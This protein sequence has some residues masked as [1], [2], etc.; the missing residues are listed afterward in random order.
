VKIGIVLEGASDKAFFEKLLFKYFQEKNTQFLFRV[1]QG[2]NNLIRQSP[3]W[4]NFFR[5]N[6]CDG[7]IVIADRDKEPCVTAVLDLFDSSIK[8][9]LK[10]PKSE[11]FF[12]VC[13]AVRGLESWLL[14]DEAAIN[15]LS[16]GCGY[17]PPNDTGGIDPK[18]T[19]KELGFTFDK[20][21]LSKSIAPKFHPDRAI[22]HSPS[23]AYFWDCLQMKLTYIE[24]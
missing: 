18:K 24:N 21:H 6:H 2:R 13:I 15:E 7:G 1:V 16:P 19:F 12:F 8:E 3:I 23:F 22:E 14:A 9:E 17:S 11:R 10:K 20:K 4:M 5:D